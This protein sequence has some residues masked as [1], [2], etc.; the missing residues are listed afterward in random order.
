MYL[1]RVYLSAKDIVSYDSAKNQLRYGQFHIRKQEPFNTALL[2]IKK[3][4][5]SQQQPTEI[6]NEWYSSQQVQQSESHDFK[7]NKIQKTNLKSNESF[8][9]L[10]GFKSN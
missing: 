7:P 8:R 6:D 4:F 2:S 10:T 3:D 5:L 1:C 9:A